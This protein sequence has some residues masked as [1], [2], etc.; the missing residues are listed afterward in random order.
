MTP[1]KLLSAVVSLTLA[2]WSALA[3]AADPP[4]A[5]MVEDALTCDQIYALGAAESQRDQHE[6]EGKLAELGSQVQTNQALLTTL[7]LTGGAIAMAAPAAI[8]AM[9]AAAY[10]AQA[11]QVHFASEM[12]K[13]VA[14]QTNPREEHL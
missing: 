1:S 14:P 6:R 3:P 4:A 7:N 2:L 5:K 10:K 13:A 9:T 12:F 11:G 8:P